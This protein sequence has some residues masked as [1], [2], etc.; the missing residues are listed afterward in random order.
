MNEKIQSYLKN[1]SAAFEKLAANSDN[2][3][4]AAELVI[5]CF[6]QG[7]KVL[8]CGN[9]GSAAD[10]QHIAGEFVGRFRKNRQPLPA[11]ALCADTAVITCIANDY[12]F[13]E[14][15]SRP[16]EALGKKGDILWAFST[17]GSSANVLKAA[18]KAKEKNIKIL[19]F[20]GKANS[21]L[22]AMADVCICASAELTC[23][24]Q[25]M[26]QI[27]YHLICEMI[28]ELY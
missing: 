6:Q 12:S 15:F 1:H 8:L 4:K 26:H 21:K 11:V 3:Q 20:T 14:I 25:E 9:G 16:V 22:E 19:A 13:D 2:I 28:D 27:V 18:E 17:S 7:G 24:A 5:S 23:I 10:S